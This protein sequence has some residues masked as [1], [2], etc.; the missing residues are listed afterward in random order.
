[1]IIDK[2]SRRQSVTYEKHAVSD[3][4]LCGNVRTHFTAASC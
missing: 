4:H 1:M 2:M 3:D